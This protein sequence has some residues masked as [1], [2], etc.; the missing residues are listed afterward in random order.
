MRVVLVVEDEPSLREVMAIELEANGFQV[1]TAR[2]GH[3]AMAMIEQERVDIVVS[4]VRMPDGDGLELL[5]RI[6]ERKTR[7]G[8]APQVIFMTGYAGVTRDEVKMRG[9]SDVLM[10]PFLI[11]DLLK[12][13]GGG[14]P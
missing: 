7:T 8:Q 10:K 5:A 6:Q 1:L 14:H 3:V 11:E 12:V 4:D 9:A 2:N 13:I